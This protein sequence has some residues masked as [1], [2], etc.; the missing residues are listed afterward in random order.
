MKTKIAN[1]K[2]RSENE[3]GREIQAKLAYARL[4]FISG[5]IRYNLDI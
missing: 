2:Q 4:S 5:I 1:I 3:K